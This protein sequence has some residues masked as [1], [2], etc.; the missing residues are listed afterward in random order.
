MEGPRT[1]EITNQSDAVVKDLI[2]AVELFLILVDH[3]AVRPRMLETA[4]VFTAVE[5]MRRTAMKAKESL[6]V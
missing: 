5:E 2:V 3:D 4:L 1:I 6:G